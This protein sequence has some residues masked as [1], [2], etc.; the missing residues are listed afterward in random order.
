MSKQC[1]RARGIALHLRAHP[2]RAAFSNPCRA[3]SSSPDA[4]NPPPIESPLEKLWSATSYCFVPPFARRGQRIRAS[5]SQE[6]ANSANGGFVVLGRPDDAASE[7]QR[8]NDFFVNGHPK[9][10]SLYSAAKLEDHPMNT[11]VPEIIVFGM[12]NAGKSTFINAVLNQN[13]AQAGKKPGKTRLLHAYAAGPQLPFS[14]GTKLHARESAPQHSLVLIDTPGYGFNSRG[15]WGK[16]LADYLRKRATLRGALV[17]VRGYTGIKAADRMLLEQLSRLN[18]PTQLIFTRMD[19]KVADIAEEQE[20]WN[21]AHEALVSA[22]VNH[23]EWRRGVG[24]MDSFFFTAAGSHLPASLKGQGGVEKSPSRSGNAG[25]MGARMAILRLAGLLSDE[26]FIT[27]RLKREAIIRDTKASRAAHG[28]EAAAAASA[29]PPKDQKDDAFAS[30]EA[31]V[32]PPRRDRH[33]GWSGETVS[34]EELRTF[35]PRRNK[36]K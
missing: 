35:A 36:S 23:P 17:L 33:E 11:F 7:L 34:F 15:E 30:L 20:T 27:A 22:E 4:P 13:V 21:A 2:E 1:L 12:S 16:H 9:R 14:Y 6:N 5:R 10:V 18:V 25:I 24:W 29:E 26:A 31:L 8:S 19:E 28:S 3:F 32:D